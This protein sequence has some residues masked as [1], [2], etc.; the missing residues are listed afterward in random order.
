LH[1]CE[2]S[3]P[4][5]FFPIFFKFGVTKGYPKQ[6]LAFIEDNFKNICP[7]FSPKN[8]KVT[9]PNYEKGVEKWQ[10]FFKNHQNFPCFY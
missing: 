8:T 9:P 2:V 10:H 5:F 4:V 7:I 3:L 1:G 6:D